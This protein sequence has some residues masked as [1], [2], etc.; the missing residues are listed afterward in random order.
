MAVP[1]VD[2]ALQAGRPGVGIVQP[3]H[4]QAV[5]PVDHADAAVGDQLDLLDVAGLEPHRRAAGQVQAHAIRLLAVEDQR[6]GW[7]RRSGSETRPGSAGRRC[8]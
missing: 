2:A 3:A 5:E 8:C 7:S 6:R 4:H 1:L